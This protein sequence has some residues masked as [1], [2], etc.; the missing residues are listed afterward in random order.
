KDC[1]KNR[2]PQYD[3][4]L[5]NPHDGAQELMMKMQN[6]DILD[7]YELDSYEFVILSHNFD[8]INWNYSKLNE[9]K[10]SELNIIVDIKFERSSY[11]KSFKMIKKI[12]RIN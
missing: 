11:K 1:L 5:K 7:S 9:N 12:I 4:L 2:Y 8:K 6:G 3:Y 10:E